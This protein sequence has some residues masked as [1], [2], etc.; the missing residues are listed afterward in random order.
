[1]TH[2]FDAIV[3][4]AGIHGACTAMNLAERGLKVVML[5]K[6]VGGRNSSTSNAGGVRQLWRHPAEIPLALEAS[7][8]WHNIEKIV[9]DDCGFR[10]SGQ[11]KIAESDKGMKILEDRLKLVK[12]LGYT[13]EE[14]IGKAE[15][16]RLVPTV[17]DHCVGALIVRSDGFA[18]PFRATHA[19]Q[20]QAI[21]NG[22]KLAVCAGVTGITKQSDLWKVKTA[23]AVYEAPI[24]VNCAGAWGD[25]IAK[26]IGDDAPVDPIAPMMMVTAPLKPFLK[27]V[28][29]S[30]TRKLSFKQAPN[31]ILLIG[32]GYRGR[33]NRDTGETIV[34]FE[35]LKECAQTV[36]DLFP[37]LKTVQI[38]RTWCGI[39][40]HT[41]DGIPYIGRSLVDPTAFHAFA[42]SSHGFQL[43][44]L[45]GKLITESILDGRSHLPLE[46]FSIGRFQK[47][48]RSHK[49]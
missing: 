26:M 28:I 21:K 44:P 48:D 10:V 35:A 14:L 7:K 42:F 40:G 43:A 30:A 25:Q 24:I 8:M 1:M 39:E 29:L 12:G 45:V 31:G 6:G 47:A 3:I 32:G 36:I 15:L 17:S 49:E 4:G 11:I 23:E 46:P 33:V 38:V 27:P 20:Q 41:P 18:S 2:G 16:K 13:H 34:N 37:H 19:F 5:D 22:A 9:G